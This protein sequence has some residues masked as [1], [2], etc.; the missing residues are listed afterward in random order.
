MDILKDGNKQRIS[1][2]V[3]EE[4]TSTLEIPLLTRL[5]SLCTAV[6]NPK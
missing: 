2:Y 5:F 1:Q 6:C 3:I 4:N